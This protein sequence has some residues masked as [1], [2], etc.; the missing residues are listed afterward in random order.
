MT[1]T[2]EAPRSPIDAMLRARSI[3]VVGASNRG[4]SFGNNVITHLTSTGYT[5]KIYPVNPR[6]D[7]IEGLP[8]YSSVSS[9][10]ERVDCA[11][12]AVADERLEAALEGAA[13]ARA[14]SAVIFGTAVEPQQPGRPLLTDRLAA[15]ARGAE[16]ALCGG[17]C[18]GFL[19]FVDSIMVGGWPYKFPPPLGH[20]GLITQS[21]SSYSG[22]A[23]N[24]R[25]LG[26]NYMISSGQELA[27][28]AADYLDFLVL[29]PETHVVGCILEMIREPERFLAALEIADKR[30]IPVVVLKLGRSERGKAMARA[31]SGAIAGADAAYQ[32]V[33]ERYNVVPVQTLNELADTL[34]LLS[35]KRAPTTDAI[36]LVTDSGGE[37]SM[38][39]DLADDRRLEF[40]ALTPQTTDVLAANLDPGLAPI[41]PVDVWGT[42]HD[43]ERITE[44]CFSALVEDPGVGQ[45]VFASNMPSGRALLHAWGRVVENVHRKSTKP[46]LMMGNLS[47][48]FDREEARRLRA[49]GIP[50]LLGT[51]SGLNALSG[52]I[53][54]HRFRRERMAPEFPSAPQAS[55]ACWTERL[56]AAGGASLDTASSL[57]LVAD[58]GMT[59]AAMRLVASEQEAASAADELGYPVVLKTLAP[60]IDHKFD[61]RGVFLGLASRDAVVGAYRNIAGRLGPHCMLQA[62]VEAGTEIFLGMTLDPHFGPLVTVGLGGVFVEVMKDVVTFLPPVDARM[63]VS[64]LRR[65]KGFPLLDGARNRSRADLNAL[66]ETVARFS[67][68]ASTLAGSVQEMDI[69]PVIATPAGAFAVD[70]LVVPVD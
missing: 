61:Q 40:A 70:A 59:T 3:A 35:C 4:E 62:Q 23:L 31:H 25:D 39:V 58:F 65:L 10:P 29:Q 13:A 42:G 37:R 26:M 57:D 21:G 50:V 5:G 14:R 49:L 8:C 1:A 11:V 22:F 51:E 32:A 44:T 53:R 69:N 68:L 67:V 16:I 34:E 12:L 2:K 63:A 60:G 56:K 6:Y 43:H 27:T 36:G 9:I 66:A 38:I 54:W 33:F 45:A 48:A 46:V 41:N 19:N 28:T 55:I 17:N 30:G 20:V 15:I 18:M 64:Y 7:L 24:Q 47:S 52:S